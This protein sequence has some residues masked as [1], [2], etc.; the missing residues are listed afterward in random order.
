MLPEN[1]PIYSMVVFV[2]GNISFIKSE[3]ENWLQHLHRRIVV[4][5]MITDNESLK[6][7]CEM[8][9]EKG[10]DKKPL[11]TYISLLKCFDRNEMQHHPKHFLFLQ[12]LFHLLG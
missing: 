3:K 8:F 9:L 10:I 4:V 11:I 1:I 7:I 12:Q 2:K 6:K 5:D